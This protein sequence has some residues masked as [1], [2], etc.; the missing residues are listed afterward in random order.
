MKTR[1]QKW[2]NSLAIRIPNNN[3]MIEKN[4][5]MSFIADLPLREKQIH[6]NYRPI[7]TIHK[8]LA[9]RPRTLFRGLL[10]AEFSNSPLSERFYKT[11]AFPGLIDF[12][13]IPLTP[14]ITE[15]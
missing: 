6:Q 8:W 10:L 2:G 5:N 12:H 11:H 1:I 4:F 14:C 3:P 9:R 15:V 13:N 7:I